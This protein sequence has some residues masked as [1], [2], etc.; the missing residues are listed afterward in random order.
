[1]A[2]YR[3]PLRDMRFLLN[4][5]FQAQQLWSKWPKVRS[6][7]DAQTLDAILEGAAKLCEQ[8]IAPLNQS[9]DAEG[10]VRTADG[11][12]V[13]PAGFKK[14]YKLF[15]E[16]GWQAL[17]GQPEFGGM[18]MPKQLTVLVEEML[19]GANNSFA[20]Y[21]ALTS[22]ACLAIA[23]HASDDLKHR[24]LP[25]LYEGRWSGSMCLTE[26]HCGTD[27]GL[28][29]TKAIPNSNGT[30]QLTGTKIFITG[31]EHDLNENII[32]LVLARL[33]GAPSGSKG[34]SLFLVPKIWVDDQ[35]ELTT[36]NQV[37]CGSIEHKMGIKASATCVLN[38]EDSKCFLVGEANQGL[39][40]MFTMMNYERLSIGLQGVGCGDNS[41]QTA[42][43]YAKNRLQG[44]DPNGSLSKSS[45]TTSSAPK[46]QPADSI[47]VHPDVRR[48]LLTM[49]AFNEG[50]R[51]FSQYAAQYLDLAKYS[52]DPG[53][54]AL[55]ESMLSLLTPVCKAFFTDKGLEMTL[56]GQQVLGGHGY[57]VDWGQEQLVRD[58]RIAQIYEGTNGIQALDLVGRKIVANEGVFYGYFSKEVHQY[59]ES[60]QQEVDLKP[61]VQQLEEA[62]QA[63]DKV[64]KHLV[65]VSKG[66]PREVGAASVEY[67]HAFGL[68]AYGFM[69]LKMIAVANAHEDSEETG[70][71]AGKIGVAHFFFAK[72]LPQVYALITSVYA[73]SDI[74]YRIND[75]DL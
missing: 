13:T 71:Y 73:G 72:C 32:H 19:Y 63:L 37:H 2:E 75:E 14:A 34:L 56:L 39:A 42:L 40:A 33:Q 18:G 53:E 51:A 47:L 48:M 43:D 11:Q 54:K 21:P 1:M 41:Y 28:I 62:I 64:T 20:L 10:V 3:V 12:V 50:G 45:L 16:G 9:G 69:W 35:G 65:E 4:E 61:L 8:E 7:T 22:G 68:V 67:L 46:D 26:P 23:A 49:R 59:L 15:A 38:F 29:K 66:N 60:L 52:E 27:L 25:P 58:A 31:G 36:F 17:G 6:V 55:G 74:L 70:F 24:F 30:Y 5:V 57:I 44:R